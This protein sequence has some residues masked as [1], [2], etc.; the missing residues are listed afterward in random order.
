MS[1][2]TKAR[3]WTELISNNSLNCSAKAE[4]KIFF[5]CYPP[6]KAGGNSKRFRLALT[7][8]PQALTEWPRRL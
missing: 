2:L 8:W 1:N 3:V 5:D 7:E 6:A 4:K